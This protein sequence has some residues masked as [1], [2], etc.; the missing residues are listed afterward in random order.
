MR[1]CIIANPR[2]GSTSL[3]GLLKDHLPQSYHCV[4]EPYNVGYMESISDT[5]NHHIEILNNDNILLKHIIYQ[6]PPNYS[7][8]DWLDWLVTHFDKVILLDRKNRIEQAES[9]EFHISKNFKNWH[10]RRVYYMDEV[11]PLKIENRINIFES[12]AN[13]LHKYSKSFPMFYYEDIFVEKNREII[14]SL[15]EYLKMEPNEKFIQHHII[16]DIKKVRISNDKR[17]L[18]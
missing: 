1:I 5:T 8:S 16:S 13:F 4:S 7:V 14:N 6:T 9:F 15:F 18:I 10:T 12:A 11:D 2:T 3:Y 17:T